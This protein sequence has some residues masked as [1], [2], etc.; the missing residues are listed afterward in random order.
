M[1]VLAVA[2]PI[3]AHLS[4][5]WPHPW[6]QW[7]ALATLCALLLHVGLRA[8]K[9]WAVCALV[10]ALAASG[11]AVRSGAG[12]WLLLLPPVAIPLSLLVV[13]AGSLRAGRRPVVTRFATM[14]RGSLPADLERYTRRV[15][16]LWVVV[17]AMLTLSAVLCAQF[18]SREVWSLVTN[19]V[20]Y[21]VIGGV[22]L[23]E[24]LYRRVFYAHHQHEGFLRQLRSMKPVRPRLP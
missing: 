3:L 22:F 18:A 6:L 7:L 24:Y 10:V 1:P 12:H 14:A 4:V 2:Y 5:V 15:T 19:F 16:V 20:H 9:P 17:L 11:L 23:G 8:R 21:L 13:F